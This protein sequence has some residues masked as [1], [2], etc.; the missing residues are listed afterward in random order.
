MD[1]ARKMSND[2]VSKN[3]LRYAITAILLL[4]GLPLH[5]LLA[6]VHPFIAWGVT[7][8]NLLTLVW[9]WLP[10]KKPESRDQT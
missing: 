1:Y 7:A 4:E 6:R 2:A 5:F 9:L 8:S 3:N 10:R